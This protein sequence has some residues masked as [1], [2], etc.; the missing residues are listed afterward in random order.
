MC[1]IADI[2]H[3]SVDGNDGQRID[4]TQPLLMPLMHLLQV[5]QSYPLFPLS[6]AMLDPRQ[7]HRRRAFEIN[8]CLERALLDEG[9]AD[10]AVD[11]IFCGIEV[12]L[13][14]HDLSEN[15]PV[16]HGGTLRVVNLVRLLLNDILPQSVPGVD[17][18]E[19]EGEGPA[20]GFLI[21]VL[22]DVDSL[23]VLPLIHGLLDGG[24]VEQR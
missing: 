23:D 21:V 13:T 15:V 7:T 8:N 2:V 24:D 14:V 6:V 9:A 4:I 11:G 19:L 20:L 18:V 22:E 1:S 10:I 16:G 3:L 5:L 12:A 17:G